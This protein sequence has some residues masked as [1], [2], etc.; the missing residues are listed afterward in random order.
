MDIL[1]IQ[2]I[3]GWLFRVSVLYVIMFLNK[4]TDIPGILPK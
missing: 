3:I 4:L 1:Y 2:N